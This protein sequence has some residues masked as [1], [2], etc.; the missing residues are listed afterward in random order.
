MATFV[1][2]AIFVTTDIGFD[3][4]LLRN[5]IYQERAWEECWNKHGPAGNRNH[6]AVQDCIKKHGNYPE[7][8]PWKSNHVR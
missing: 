7:L 1:I 3:L 6:T 2:G 5:Y 4:A 8:F